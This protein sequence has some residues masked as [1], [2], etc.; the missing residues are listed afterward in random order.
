MTIQQRFISPY[1]WGI[2]PFA[3]FGLTLLIGKSMFLY[4]VFERT[5]ESSLTFYNNFFGRKI[6]KL[7]ISLAEVDKIRTSQ[8]RKNY[9]IVKLQLEDGTNYQLGKFAV[10]SHL[11]PFEQLVN[12]LIKT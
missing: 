4:R 3:G 1:L 7:T 12:D 2:L 8:D 6:N 5:N 11:T 10:K 9:F